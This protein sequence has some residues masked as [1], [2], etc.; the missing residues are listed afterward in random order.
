MAFEAQPFAPFRIHLIDGK[1]CD[2]TYPE[3]VWVFP[4]RIEIAKPSEKWAEGLLEDSDYVGLLHIV[5]TEPIKQA[6]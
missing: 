2:L 5:R 3:L 1:T 6:A 4:T